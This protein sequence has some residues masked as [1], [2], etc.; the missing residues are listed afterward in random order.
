MSDA[1]MRQYIRYYFQKRIVADLKTIMYPLLMEYCEK[2][3]ATADV[4]AIISASAEGTVT[5]MSVIEYGMGDD[6][7][8]ISAQDFYY[9][10]QFI[11]YS[12]ILKILFIYW[13]EKSAYMNC[14]MI[15]LYNHS[16]I[17][18]LLIFIVPIL[19]N[20]VRFTR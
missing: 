9:F 3:K 7:E 14:T 12:F 1:C 20:I 8:G 17:Y 13:N 10:L 15:K 2:D 5:F 16:D 4:A 6:A 18:A 19:G 11:V